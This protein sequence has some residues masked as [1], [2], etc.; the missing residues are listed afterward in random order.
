MFQMMLF[1]PLGNC[2][3][4]GSDISE[5]AE[6]MV[7][8]RQF[9]RS[10]TRQSCKQMTG[11]VNIPNEEEF[12]DLVK[13][14]AEVFH[15]LIN[16]APGVTRFLGNSSFRCQRGFPSFRDDKIVY[17]SKRN[18]DK[19]YIGRDAFVPTCLGLQG[20][21]YYR[22]ENKPSVDT[23]VQLRLYEQL[24][25]I[26][27]MMHAHVYVEGAPFTENMIPCGGLEEVEEVVRTLQNKYGT[28]NS[29]FYAVNL[30]GHGS[31]VMAGDVEKLKGIS[32]VGRTLPE[33]QQ[34]KNAD[35]EIEYP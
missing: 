14:N 7:S 34:Y 9:L 26:R 19:R 12:F 30:V 4:K 16:P 25:N 21:V 24:P 31:I 15:E 11:T 6:N 32:Y 28:L 23:P 35:M 27:Y 33:T 13:Q 17:V 3:Y 10:V 2:W 29:D 20:E 1:D 22:G 18:V 8:R 5:C